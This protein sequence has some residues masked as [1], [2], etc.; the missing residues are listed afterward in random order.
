MS[1]AKKKKRVGP[2]SLKKS[3]I[4]P[5]P[6]IE[7]SSKQL[8]YSLIVT[9]VFLCFAA[10]GLWHHEMW[11][12]EH[13]AW[14]VARDA[15]SL[16]QLFQNIRYEGNPG[17]WHSLLYLITCFS[18]NPVYMQVLHLMIACG[19]IYVFNRY[20]QVSNFYKILFSFGYFPLYEYAVI[21]RSYGLGVLL[22][23]L[24]CALYKN[25][26]SHYILLGIFLALIANVTIFPMVIAA[27]IAGLLI[28][29][30]LL[31]QEKN[32]KN[33]VELTT[34]ILIFIS[35]V[36]FMLWQIWPDKNNSF[37]V[38]YASSF[39]DSAR[40]SVIASKLFTT[41]F[42]IPKFQVN[43]WNT[44]LYLNDPASGAGITFSE[45]LA[46]NATHAWAWLYLPCLV[47]IS[48][49]II[50]LR[51][52]LI[53]LLYVIATVVLLFIYYYTG[54]VHLRYCGHLL[55]GL[56][57]CYW[58][59]GY[60][61]DK[62]YQGAILQFFANLGDK[63]SKP[64][65][66]GV[67]IFNIIGALVAFTMDYQ[68]KFSTSK[69]AADYIRKNNLDTLTIAGITDFTASPLA[70]Y[71]DTKI[72]YPQMDA[73]GS[74]TVWSKQRSTQMTFQQLLSKIEN[75]MR[76]GHSSILLVKDTAPQISKDGKTFFPLQHGSIAKDIQ[77]D[78]LT[79]FDAGIVSDEKY[80]IYKVQKGDST[81]V[82]FNTYPLLK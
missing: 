48:G 10:F 74:F 44:S 4:I 8:R 17:L 45:W 67:F 40:W 62:K 41:Y 21:S 49:V 9:G 26:K 81:N 82:D 7:E 80:F 71:L 34:G 27:G 38:A 1:K 68:Y 24:V 77:I 11:R 28:L 31:Y 54:L 23:F 5:E 35:G 18:N 50:F 19:F 56:V 3:E 65:L 12:D 75:F 59:G 42:Y 25:R 2:S 66:A 58:L 6:L 79:S 51:K 16:S 37:P 73:F 29:D 78:F 36:V 57:I 70:S 64:F 20:A 43:F 22:L 32:K 69:D 72:Y 39:F 61:R 30:Y 47:F 13:Q 14:L 15:H 76:Q 33:T 53:L 63:I 55:I 46:A 60:Y 52:P